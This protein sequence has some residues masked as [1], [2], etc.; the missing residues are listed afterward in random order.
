MNLTC[1]PKPCTFPNS[2]ASEGGQPVN[3][4]PIS[5]NPKNPQ[6]ILTAGNDYNCSSALQGYYL[7]SDGGSTWTR[8]CGAIATG[9][10]GGDGD[11]VVAWDTNNTAYRGGIDS[12]SNGGLEVVVDSSTNGGSSWSTPVIAVPPFFTGGA[13]DKPWME[14]DTSAASSRLGNVYVSV[15]QFDS[16]NNSDITVSTSKDHG[17][18]WKTVSVGAF[19]NYPV[20]NQFSD[21][22]IGSDGTVYVS[23]MRCTANGSTS[24]CGGTV[25]TMLMSK[26]TNGGKTWSPITTIGTANLAPDSCGAFYGCL[27]NTAERVSDIPVSAIDNSNKSHAGALYVTDYTFVNSHMTVQVTASADG[28]TTWSPPVNVAPKHETHDQF[29]PWVNVSGKGLVG[30][31][32]MDRRND[33]ANFSY[34]EFGAFSKD[35]TR[36]KNFQLAAAESSPNNDGFG[37]G[38]IGDYTGNAWS[39]TSLYASWTDTSN[40]VSGQDVIGGLLK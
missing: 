24:D 20:V 8:T 28:G 36:F 3:E 31:T 7:S 22:S 14:I 30:V 10:P 37:D 18:T 26:S 12:T 6:Q 27:P 21:L 11:P 5:I 19:Q 13:A 34:E 25:A 29:F 1:S 32:W 16:S 9:S 23:W 33:P 15:T 4:T 38:F 2:Q 17:A 39:G 35:G 40:G